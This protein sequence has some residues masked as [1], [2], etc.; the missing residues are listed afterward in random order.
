MTG[1]L[2]PSLL[3]WVVLRHWQR[4]AC[5]AVTGRALWQQATAQAAWIAARTPPAA[6]V[7]VIG[8]TGPAMM[9]LFLG[10]AASGR[11]AAFFPPASPL[12][13]A[14]H[15]FE[16]QG[17]ALRA[18]DPAAIC[19]MEEATA[20]TVR[21][22]APDLAPRILAVPPAEG[23][24]VAAL[25]AFRARLGSDETLFVQHSSG[26]TGIKKAVAISGRMLAAQSA[27]YWPGLRAELGVARLSVASWLP[28]Y[29]D[30]GLVA[31]FLLPMLGG[32]QVSV[33]DPF[34][35]IGSPGRF[36]EMIAADRCD[37]AWM[38]NFAYRHFV[39][40]RRALPPADLSSLRLWVDCSEPCRLADA[41][42]F[43]SAFADRGVRPGAVVGCYAMAET[44]FAVSQGSGARRRGLA[45]PGPLA[46]GTPMPASGA[47][48]VESGTAAPAGHRLVLSSGRVLPG[49]ELAILDGERRLPPGHYGEIALRAPFLFSGHAGRS[50]A[51]SGLDTEGYYRT[52]D[53]GTVWEEEVFVFGRLKEIIIVN[54]K[55]LFAGDVEAALA[56][57]PGL[58]PGRAVAFGIDSDQTGSEELILVAEHDAASGIPEAECRAAISRHLERVFLVKPR[59]VRVVPDRWLVKSTSGKISR[60]ANR[61]RYLETFR[62]D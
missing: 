37:I 27:A 47:L 30:M 53:L 38:P 1:L 29:H 56:A 32:D 9:A 46:P 23:D 55:N 43:E 52:G 36:L 39:R 12:Q 41:E 57:L 7:L 45:V 2:D 62:Q 31:G 48:L 14:R 5:T 13:D 16:Q 44:V 4:G 10:I 35:W 3:D 25:D 50:A 40:L 22:I 61:R 21:A 26:T 34:E 17:A 42:G 51:E 15:F 49:V 6:L 60:D 8:T 11:R 54:G 20:E 33:L 19:V 18:I 59:D 28:L 24:S 58:R